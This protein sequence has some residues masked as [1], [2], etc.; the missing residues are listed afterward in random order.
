M[1]RPKTVRQVL[2]YPAMGLDDSL[3][4]E[5]IPQ[6]V[7]WLIDHAI[8]TA[9]VLSACGEHVNDEIAPE[10]INLLA[11]GIELDL[12]NAQRILKAWQTEQRDERSVIHA[13]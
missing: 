7:A 5:M 3:G 12:E 4:K 9:D 10:S 1:S 6:S 11:W 2:E 13:V 8:A